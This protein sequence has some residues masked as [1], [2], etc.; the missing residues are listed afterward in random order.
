MQRLENE[1]HVTRNLIFRDL[2]IGY[3][4]KLSAEA[5]SWQGSRQATYRSLRPTATPSYCFVSTGNIFLRLRSVAQ[6]LR[7]TWH[8][9]NARM[10]V[11]SLAGAAAAAAESSQYLHGIFLADG[12]PLPS[13][14]A[15]RRRRRRPVQIG[16]NSRNFLFPNA[17]AV[18]AV[19]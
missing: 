9:L 13:V 8:V 17:L 3:V 5:R 11:L 6:L 19:T 4:G 18:P 14:V 1:D 12:I 7:L 2:P 16:V 10:P 15:L